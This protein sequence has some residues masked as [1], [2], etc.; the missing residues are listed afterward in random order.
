MPVRI[1]N[2]PLTG[3]LLSLA[4]AQTGYSLLGLALRA[5]GRTIQNNSYIA[6]GWA[7]GLFNIAI[8][9]VALGVILLCVWYVRRGGYPLVSLG[10]LAG[11][12]RVHSGAAFAMTVG[13]LCLMGLPPT[14]GFLGKAFVAAALMAHGPAFGIPVALHS[15]V[16]GFIGVSILRAMFLFGPVG[17]EEPTHEQHTATSQIARSAMAV[18]VTAM[19]ILGLMPQA[20]M[21]TVLRL[22]N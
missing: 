18:G 3:V 9:T 6:D 1:R 8:S 14:G 4:I 11:L 13:V 22:A 20:L 10:D 12:Y 16:V 17:E 2:T 19:L 5:G 15:L 21:E 7:A